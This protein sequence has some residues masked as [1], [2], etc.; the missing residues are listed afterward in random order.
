MSKPI[1]LLD[2]D[3]VINAFQPSTGYEQVEVSGY[4]IRYRRDI[5]R[6]VERLSDSYEIHWATMWNHRVREIERFLGIGPFPVMTC[7]F[8]LGADVLLAEGM[9]YRSMR[10]LWWA[11][12]PLI[13]AYVGNRA[14]A[15]VDDDHQTSDIRYLGARLPGQR[16]R[17]LR[18]NADSGL[19]WSDVRALEEWAQA[20]EVTHDATGTG[21][22]R[23]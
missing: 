4:R 13:P 1:L 8:D 22:S 16:F 15:W 9:D 17:L 7:S 20:R 5:S 12:T 14:F 6:M 19:S 10:S 23:A 3:G 11:K 21:S 2:V 18:T